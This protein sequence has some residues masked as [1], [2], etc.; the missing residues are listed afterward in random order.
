[1]DPLSI[2]TAS[3]G[4]SVSVLKISKLLYTGFDEVQSVGSNLQI[5]YCELV[6]LS[7]SLQSLGDGLTRPDFHKAFPTDGIGTSENFKH[8][9][10]LKIVISDCESSVKQLEMVL[11]KISGGNGFFAHGILRKPVKALQLDL[12]SSELDRIRKQI[13]TYHN[14]MQLSLHMITM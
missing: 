8:L 5:F 12:K 11:D 1:M 10:S 4:L 13:Q 3:I 9:I 14:A 7:N 2:A 6:T